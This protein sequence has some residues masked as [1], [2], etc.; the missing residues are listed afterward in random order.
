MVSICVMI[1]PTVCKMKHKVYWR[2]NNTFQFC[3]NMV[4]TVRCKHFKVS[5][6]R[7]LL[8]G[9]SIVIHVKVTFVCTLGV[10]DM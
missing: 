2:E 10:I 3:V 9:H 4:S 7:S 6:I 8:D 1:P 5:A